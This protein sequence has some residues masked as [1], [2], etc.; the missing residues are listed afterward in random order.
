MSKV[1]VLR[2]KLGKLS[3]CCV[4]HMYYVLNAWCTVCWHARTYAYGHLYGDAFLRIR[5]CGD[6]LELANAYMKQFNLF[7]RL[8]LM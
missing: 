1:T 4:V 7:N 5:V 8:A 6:A 3:G 2:A